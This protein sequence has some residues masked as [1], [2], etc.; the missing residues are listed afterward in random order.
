[1]YFA[2]NLRQCSARLFPTGVGP[3]SIGNLEGSPTFTELVQFGIGRPEQFAQ[4]NRS[5]GLGAGQT[6]VEPA[7]G[8]G[9]LKQQHLIFRSTAKSPSEPELFQGPDAPLRRVPMPPPHAIAVVM[10]E[11]VVVVMIALAERKNCH[12]PAVPRT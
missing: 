10:L 5:L 9:E 2:A 1:M 7:S 8:L 11:L 3:F 4:A 6:G 12:Q